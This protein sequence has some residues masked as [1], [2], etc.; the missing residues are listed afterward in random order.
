MSEVTGTGTFELRGNVWA[1][2]FP[3]G[4]TVTMKVLTADLE[5]LH[6]VM[7]RTKEEAGSFEEQLREEPYDGEEIL[8][9]FFPD[10][11]LGMSILSRLTRAEGATP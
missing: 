10:H 9:R 7:S 4:L 5:Y 11:N 8:R 6:A 1:F 3:D 2:T